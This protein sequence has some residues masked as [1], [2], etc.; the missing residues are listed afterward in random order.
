MK[1]CFILPLL[2]ILFSHLALAENPKMTND[3]VVKLVKAGLSKDLIVKAIQS[4]EPGFATSSDALLALKKEG[5]S[6]D[7][8]AAIITRSGTLPTAAGSNGS[9]PPFAI[10][11][12][13]TPDVVFFLPGGDQ[14][15]IQLKRA[16]TVNR[17]GATQA[18]LMPFG[19]VKNREA[20][21]GA[22]SSLRIA[23]LPK[24][25]MTIPVDLRAAEY[26][27][28]AKLTVKN[29]RREIETGRSYGFTGSVGIRKGAQIPVSFE[30]RGNHIT[31]TPNTR[32]EP[33]EY[34]V[35]VNNAFFYDFGVNEK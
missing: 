32:L 11:P 13:F 9:A 10:Q 5:V 16:I 24:F 14:P 7:I 35:I 29:D 18:F 27:C 28:V 26:V 30:Q 8:I 2:L 25:Q 34:C 21:S 4:S 33:G 6:D 31:F 20:F 1:T 3:D 12:G 15:P 19:G 22:H 23:A 17:S